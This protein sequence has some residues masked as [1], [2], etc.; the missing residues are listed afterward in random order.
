[1]K[2]HTTLLFMFILCGVLAASCENEIPFNPGN[3]PPKLVMNA[4]INADS[5]RNVLFL[6]LT[7]HTE[8]IPVTDA[9]VEVRIDGQLIQTVRAIPPV[10]TNDRPNRY[11]ITGRFLP[12]QLVRIDALTPDGKHHAWAEVTVPQRPEKIEK[13]DT[14]RVTLANGYSNYQ[15]TYMRHKISIADRINEPNY[16]RL[17]V[18]TLIEY[19]AL[20]DEE[21]EEEQEFRHISYDI[22]NREDVVL[23][24]G[25]PYTNEDESNGF[26]DK[27]RNVYNVFDNTRF[28]DNRYVMT[29]YT[30]FQPYLEREVKD[31]RIQALIRLQSINETEFHYLKVLN[32][33]DSDAYDETLMEPIKFPSNVH[34][35][36]GM[37]GI[38]TETSYVQNIVTP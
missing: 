3:H 22:I 24:D 1:M 25:E 36:T 12:G 7:D 17:I 15:S 23:T 10:E 13:V 28:R 8:T 31:L 5:T 29:I 4:L 33:I 21:H 19:T 9:T 34:G 32:V 38:S 30:N 14:A 11:L 20:P 18:E 37:V 16:Y 6:N 27:A 35:G 26:F 2:T